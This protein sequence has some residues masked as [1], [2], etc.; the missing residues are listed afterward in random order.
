VSEATLFPEQ[1]KHDPGGKVRI[2]LPNGMIGQAAF[3]DCQRY[4]YWLS[5]SWGGGVGYG[6]GVLWIGMNPSTADAD[7]DDPTVRREIGFTQR[8][9]F[10]TYMKCNV[11][12]YRATSPKRLLEKGVLPS[13]P[14]NIPTI[15]RLAERADRII[16]CYGVLPPKLQPYADDVVALLDGAG[17]EMWC[18]GFSRDGR[19]P[20][21]PLYL[22][23][24]TQLI[25]FRR[26]A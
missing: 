5:R 3:S 11:M 13:S 22:K 23:N 1:P 12:D 20:K 10:H 14:Q 4:R 16:V 25:P 6:P 18:L 19:F 26:P 7:V 21:H 2:Q 8:W 17:H 24:D 15:M 9:G